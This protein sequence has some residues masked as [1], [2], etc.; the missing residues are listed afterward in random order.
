MGNH[1]DLD[2]PS[3][4]AIDDDQEFL[5]EVEKRLRDRYNV[6]GVAT[7]SAAMATLKDRDFDG[8]LLDMDMPE[9]GGL[10]LLKILRGLKAHLP[11]LMLTGN[12]T[13]TRIV[14][15]IKEGAFDYVVKDIDDGKEELC[16]R[17]DR[18]ISQNSLAQKA[19]RL[20][21]LEKEVADEKARK[22]QI[23]GTSDATLQ[24]HAFIHQLKG[25][26][27]SVLISGESG[28]GKELI[29]RALNLQDTGR[30]Q[31][32]FIAVNCGAIQDNLIESEL[33]GHEKGAFTGAQ[34]R[35][36][37]RFIAANGGDI[38]LDEI[39]ELSPSAQAKLL[40]V[41]QEREV[42]RVGSND[43]VKVNVRVIAASHR[44]LRQAV[45]DGHFRED[46]Y[47]RLAVVKIESPPLR[48]RKEDIGL[49]TE[50]FLQDLGTSLR[51]AP[52]ALRV[53]NEHEW[54]GN[55]RALKNCIERA[56]ILAQVDNW[57][58]IE[59][60]HIQLDSIVTNKPVAAG[61]VQIPQEFLPATIEDVKPDRLTALLDWVESE[62]YGR[63]YEL[64]GRNKSRLAERMDRSRDMIHRKL[65][66][67]GIGQ[68]ASL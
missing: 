56:I 61:A 16:F 48:K 12:R 35:K 8:I 45:I 44:D 31:R 36:D 51:L 4:L 64:V 40:R 18:M 25:H 7:A 49:L 23:V 52:A 68:G 24:L 50:H 37:G 10:Q 63:A 11:V 41:L 1:G 5:V 20:E 34:G 53:L 14:T 15:A 30:T 60:R 32:P 58:R 27:T 33:F 59:D 26:Q 46:L 55:I 54:P 66:D 13:T 39:A 67:F 9:V 17:I 42:C 65:K 57:Y 62:F 6:H 2:K 47:Y 28:T 21:K 22:Y 38:F 3:L 19:K 29:A 43:A